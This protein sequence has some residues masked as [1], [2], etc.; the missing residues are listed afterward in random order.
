MVLEKGKCLQP[1]TPG[2]KSLLYWPTR[3]VDSYRQ[4][5]AP[6]TSQS[7]RSLNNGCGECGERNRMTRSF[8]PQALGQPCPSL[9]IPWLTFGSYTVRLWE[10]VCGALG[11]TIKSCERAG[12][13]LRS[14]RRTKSEKGQPV[15]EGEGHERSE[16]RVLPSFRMWQENG[17]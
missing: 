12:S 9:Y 4:N 10:G 16:L 15:R 5:I 17:I 7:L 6:G 14:Q 1:N 8:L 3:L 11:T 13:R 2:L